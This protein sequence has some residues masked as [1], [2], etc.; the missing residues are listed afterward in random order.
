MTMEGGALWGNAYKLLV[1]NR[2]DGYMVNG[3]RCPNVGVSGF[4]LG[5]GIG[6]F[7]RS[8]GMACDH[9]REISI[10][11]ADGNLVTVRSSDDPWTPKGKLFWALCGAGGGNFG[12]VVE[13]KIDVLKMQ[14]HGTVVASSYTHFPK[15]DRDNFVKGMNK[16]YTA[17]W[18]DKMTIDSTWLVDPDNEKGEFGVRFNSYFDGDE[19]CYKKHVMRNLVDKNLTKHLVR[20]AIEERSTRFLHESLVKMLNT[21]T[22]QSYPSAEAY[23]IF[24]SFVFQ[25]D[26]AT[27]EMITVI[28]NEELL[29]FEKL[30]GTEKASVQVSFIHS[31]GQESKRDPTATAF[32]WRGAVFNTYLQLRWIDKWLERDIRGF[33][34]RFKARLR[35]LSMA[36]HASYVNFPDSSLDPKHHEKAYYGHNHVKLSEVKQIWDKNNYWAWTQGVNLPGQRGSYASS[37]HRDSHGS[38][39][40][41]QLVSSGELQSAVRCKCLMSMMRRN[42]RIWRRLMTRS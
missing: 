11:T 21:E 3:G 17:D 26:L 22:K 7:G 38:H 16:F 2:L 32:Y 1:N 37:G 19:H 33:G 23:T 40:S 29:A 35:P 25:R 27:I 4:L 9:L 5:G 36:G 13:L 8:L 14:G 30:F 15:E 18:P 12:V 34:K 10:V 6:P 28:V 41:Q 24:S 42:H 20:R 39:G 31:G